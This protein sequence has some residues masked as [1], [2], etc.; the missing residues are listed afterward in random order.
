MSDKEC[1]ETPKI[2]KPKMGSR[3]IPGIE[4]K[5]LSMDTPV[6]GVADKL[7]SSSDRQKQIRTEL[8]VMK[9]KDQVEQLTQL[10][11]RKSYP[12]NE[13]TTSTASSVDL[14]R[15]NTILREK[16]ERTEFKLTDLQNG[17]VHLQSEYHDETLLLQQQTENLMKT[18]QEEKLEKAKIKKD[19]EKMAKA[20]TVR[21]L[22]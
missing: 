3:I 15:E 11:H 18:I 12:H 10:V 13:S 8:D 5:L 9:L 19:H 7:N 22:F 21:F 20:L 14:E 16:L 2:I 17:I 6:A 4:V 1:W